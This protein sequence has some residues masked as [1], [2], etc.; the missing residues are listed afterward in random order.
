MS[1][2][3]AFFILGIALFV[4][5]VVLAIVSA[6]VF[7]SKGI[8]TV[9][10]D[11]SGKTRGNDIRNLRGR[12]TRQRGKA[13][14]GDAAS[15]AGGRF[16]VGEPSPE[17]PQVGPAGEVAAGNVPEINYDIEDSSDDIPTVVTSL[18]QYHTGGYAHDGGALGAYD[19]LET[20]VE[21]SGAVASTFRVTRRIVLVHSD[22]VITA[23]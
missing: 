7:V 21:D 8:R 12:V 19:D 14:K 2:Q 18:D 22:G 15:S 1:A 3:R 9:M 11:L 10:D 16:A 6:Y 23:G 4:A 20:A 17:A 5:A 13:A